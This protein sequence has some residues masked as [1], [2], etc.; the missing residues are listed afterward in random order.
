MPCVAGH[1]AVRIDELADFGDGGFGEIATAE[2][3]GFADFKATEDRT[4]SIGN[5][6]SRPCGGTQV[7][8]RLVIVFFF[9]RFTFF[10]IFIPCTNGERAAQ[11]HVY[12]G[13]IFIA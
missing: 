10:Q 8:G 6:T 2:C 3:A 4:K 1:D 7:A 9:V 5:P 11:L 13:Q 12:G